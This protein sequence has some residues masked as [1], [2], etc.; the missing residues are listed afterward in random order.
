M[1]T[2]PRRTP[3]RL[4]RRPPPGPHPRLGLAAGYLVVRSLHLLG[5]AA[6]LPLA[7]GFLHDEAPAVVTGWRLVAML[8]SVCLTGLFNLAFDQAAYPTRLRPAL[9]TTSALY[10]NMAVSLWVTGEGL[11]YGAYVGWL[12]LLVA[13]GL[14]LGGIA[15]AGV[16]AHAGGPGADA[17]VWRAVPR[18]LVGLVGAL[19]GLA[20]AGALG[21][22]A[23]FVREVTALAA[24]PLA[25]AVTVGAFGWAVGVTTRGWWYGSVF[26]APYIEADDHQASRLFMS[27]WA[28]PTAAA[29]VL[30]VVGALLVLLW[31][32]P[33]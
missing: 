15:V 12:G 27:Q 32:R 16:V 19:A 10:G 24:S 2:H 6:A 17:P 30:T 28:A 14:L 29:Y 18:G 8:A 31:P 9:V 7:L 21:C 22:A 33:S 23:P 20:L 1:P 13:L 26:A 5:M 11:G 3:P 4:A 25:V